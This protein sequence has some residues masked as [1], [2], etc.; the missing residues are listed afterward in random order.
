MAKSSGLTVSHV[1]GGFA[2][3]WLIEDCHFV[4]PIETGRIAAVAHAK[5][6][7]VEVYTL[8]RLTASKPNKFKGIL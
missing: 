8:I 3:R 2:V 7:P 1:A 6:A 5:C 4:L